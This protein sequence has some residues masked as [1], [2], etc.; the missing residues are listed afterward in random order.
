M[1]D[2]KQERRP[3]D[4]S[5]ISMQED[6]EVQYWTKKFNCSREDLE[7]AVERV[8]NGAAAVER[9]LRKR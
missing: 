7:R 9:E 4:A 6:Y 8:G 1:S 5:R 3:Q 2:N